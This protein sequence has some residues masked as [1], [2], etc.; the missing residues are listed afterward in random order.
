MLNDF[1]RGLL[2]FNRLLTF[3]QAPT[4]RVLKVE[5]AMQGT[6]DSEVPES[7]ETD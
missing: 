1:Y 2:E 5:E 6:E 7:L 3:S 4:G